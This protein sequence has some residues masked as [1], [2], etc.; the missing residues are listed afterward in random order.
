MIDSMKLRDHQQ[1]ALDALK[2]ANKGSIYCPTGGGKTLI[3]IFDCLRRLNE[4]Q[5]PMT[6]VVCAP[7]I[8]LASQLEAEFS[9][10]ILSNVAIPAH[11]HSGETKHFKTT[12][13]DKI[14]GFV[15]MAEQSNSHRILYT[16]YHSLPKIID[17][18]IDIDVI[19][20]DE[21]HNSTGRNFFTSVF[22][23]SQ[24]AQNCYYFTA[25]PR[26][27]QKHAR[28][29]NNPEVYGNVLMNIPAPKLIA[30]GSIIPPKVVAH[31]TDFLR[32]KETAAMV[33]SNTVVDIVDSLDESAA[34]KILVAAPSTKILWNM[35]S[36]SDVL[37]RLSER[38]YDILHITSKHGAY[39]NKQKVNRE[40]FFDT[41]TEWGKDPQRKFILLHYSILSEGI[42]VPGLTHTI[43]LRNLNIVEM[44]QTIGRVIRVDRQDAE[45][46][47]T[48]VLVP[49]DCQ[50]YRKP[51]GYVTVPVYTNYG[52]QIVKR[53]QTVVDAI[54]LKG[55][56]PLALA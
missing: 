52:S 27:S 30:N 12:N 24:Y 13:P 9:E 4:A 31:E 8:L 16:T 51:C 1:K 15:K 55:V 29:M 40:V 2:S 38:G 33:D 48:G 22:A 47:A 56:P 11:I 44:A 23:I 18:G 6:I 14:A 46:I 53:L 45:D 50:F 20:Y 10:H 39:V 54:F 43:L 25:T 35:L 42:N 41:L 36:Q 49:G 7:R 17:S 19:Y 21:A 32:S 26:I 37:E 28:G 3:M 5:R 34:A